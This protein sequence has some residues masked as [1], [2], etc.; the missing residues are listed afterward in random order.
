M[1]TITTYQGYLAVH[2]LASVLWVGG[3]AAT[4]VFAY[5]ASSSGDPHRLAGFSADAEWIGTRVF[6]PSSLVLV[7]FGFL[8]I[9][10]LDTG[11]PFWIVFA[12]VVW[13]ASAL[14]GSLFLG[15]ESGRIS[16]VTEA[17]GVESPEV[18]RRTRRIFLI[19][20][21]EL[22]LLILVVLDMTLKPFS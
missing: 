7:V 3:A 20:R 19:S 11:Y 21:I 6:L 9:H 10:E 2:I 18:Q 5:R 12:L 22:T 13:A 8:L 15:P 4:Q 1:A 17:E 14:T 16:K